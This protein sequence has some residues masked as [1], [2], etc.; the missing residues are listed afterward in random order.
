[1]SDLVF[2]PQ[3]VRVAGWTLVHFL[4]QA[5]LICAGVWV[6]RSLLRHHE[7]AWRYGVA[8]A[9]L[10]AMTL[11]ACVTAFLLARSEPALIPFSLSAGWIERQL[12]WITFAWVLGVTGLSLRLAGGW[13]LLH[14]LKQLADP[15]HAGLQARVDDIGRGLG[16]SRPVRVLRSALVRVPMVVGWFKPVIMIPGSLVTGIPAAELEALLAHELGH[17]RRLD[18]LVNGLQTFLETVFFFHPGVWW[19]SR[20]IRVE[21]EHC[22]DDLALTTTDRAVYARALLELEELKGAG[23]TF[24]FAG[25]RADG[26]HL[27]QRIRRLVSTTESRGGVVPKL[28]SALAIAAVLLGS[29]QMSDAGRAVIVT[30]P[31]V[32]TSLDVDARIDPGAPDH[33]LSG[34]SLVEAPGLAVEAVPVEAV[35]V[36]PAPVAGHAST[37]AEAAS[38]P[39]EIAVEPAP[40]VADASGRTGVWRPQSLPAFLAVSDERGGKRPGSG[41]LGIGMSAGLVQSSAVGPLSP[42]LEVR[43]LWALDRLTQIEAS[44]AFSMFFHENLFAYTDDTGTQVQMTTNYEQQL[45]LSAGIR[46]SLNEQGAVGLY[47]GL[48]GGM[49]R[50]PI[51]RII[52][53]ADRTADAYD[54]KFGFFFL[55]K[56]GYVTRVNGPLSWDLNAG[57]SVSRVNGV[58]FVQPVMSLGVNYWK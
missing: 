28:A 55:P 12:P 13:F 58:A 47:Y 20:Q 15:V 48:S 2:D 39:A 36:R 1:M 53:D 21:R 45:K 30:P 41:R 46:R 44:A 51:H 24:S 11:S 50:V 38:S 4:W 31:A 25:V 34:L 17:I 23:M 9:G 40:P 22:C 8:C 19:V 5:G 43:G 37:P 56:V 18:T 49:I 42:N 6:A 35:P 32:V 14:R 33:E 16:L 27:V 54:S 3:F 7:A 29:V 26:G 57:L 52:G 10:V